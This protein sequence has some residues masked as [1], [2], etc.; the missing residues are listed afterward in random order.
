MLSQNDYTTLLLDFLRSSPTAFHA[1]STAAALLRDKGFVQL[2]EQESWNR[3]PVGKYFVLRN[4][5]SLLGFTWHSGQP[6]SGFKMIGAHTDSPVLKVKPNPLRK[7]QNCLQLGVEIYGGALLRPWFDRELSLAGRIAW[8][9][10]DGRLCST[11]LDFQRPVGIIP[12]L[13]IHLHR[14]ANKQQEINNQTDM[15]PLIG[16]IENGSNDFQQILREQLRHQQPEAQPA[17]FIDHELFF[18]DAMPPSLTGLSK[19]FIVSARLDNLVS[20]FAAVQALLTADTDENCLIIL[21]DHE[22]V[23]STSAVGAQGPFLR[24][25][26]ERLLPDTE[27]RQTALRSSFFIS[28]DNAHAVH[29]NYAA[30]HDPQHLPHLGK[31]PV[32][33]F[34]ANQRYATNAASAAR[35]RQLCAQAEVPVQ[36]FVS[37]SDLAC[38]STI[39]PLTAAGIGIDTVD[40]GIP[41]LAMH[42]IRETAACIDC[43]HLYRVLLCFF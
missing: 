3:L 35:F 29:P 31:G 12:S 19:E 38:G 32:L 23:G 26:L 7:E 22:E 24:D 14:E 39:G 42:S 28:A 18:Y 36:D 43:W 5:S 17:G 9:E 41:S 30:K 20:C 11:L 16:L 40:I 25:I 33:K 4:D 21:N 13:A 2:D 27:N 34:N 1:A 6:S 37:R 8:Q 15:V 10:A